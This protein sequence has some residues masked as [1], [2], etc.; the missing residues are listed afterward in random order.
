M[1]LH[2]CAQH[3]AVIRN[4]VDNHPF[5]IAKINFT[6]LYRKNLLQFFLS[7][8]ADETTLNTKTIVENIN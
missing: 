4:Y 3:A 7:F 8:L 5:I 2:R 1:C 6:V